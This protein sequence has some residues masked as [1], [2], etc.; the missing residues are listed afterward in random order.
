MFDNSV[1]S[2]ETVALLPCSSLHTEPS[3]AKGGQA[4][5][6]DFSNADAICDSYARANPLDSELARSASPL[7]TAP[8]PA[9]STA[10]GVTTAFL[11]SMD[12][13]AAGSPQEGSLAEDA[14]KPCTGQ[15]F[16]VSLDAA[17][18]SS[19]AILSTNADAAA[20]TALKQSRGSAFLVDFSDAPALP[21]CPTPQTAGMCAAANALPVRS[22]AQPKAVP[23]PISKCMKPGVRTL[24]LQLEVPPTAP[25]QDKAQVCLKLTVPKESTGKIPKTAHAMTL[26]ADHR[27]ALSSAR[28]DMTRG[29]FYDEAWKDQQECT[30][31]RYLNFIFDDVGATTTHEISAPSS[32]LCIRRAF[33]EDFATLS[34][35]RSVFEGSFFQ[36]I[37]FNLDKEIKEGRLCIRTDRDIC[38]DV[39]LRDKFITMLHSYHPFWLR[40]G[41]EAVLKESIPRHMDGDDRVALTRC[42]KAKVVLDTSVSA[43]VTYNLEHSDS[44]Q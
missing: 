14:A 29:I 18:S 32:R 15:A 11:A 30:F 42:I 20:A 13:P 36:P 8:L 35:L 1:V 12:S 24:K 2:H 25:E 19:P 5:F 6:V 26:E 4:F 38:N 9:A 21:P 41:L 31:A 16:F 44:K 22:V 28:Q 39:G 40:A 33:R 27:Q 10:T 17:A 3:Q 34:K 7:P 37:L 43:A 23:K